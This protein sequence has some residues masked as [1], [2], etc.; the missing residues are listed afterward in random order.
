LPGV[1]AASFVRKG[2]GGL[3]HVSLGFELLD[4]LFETELFTLEF[5]DFQAIDEGVRH[6]FF[7]LPL[8]GLMLL[9]QFLDMRKKAHF[10]GLHFCLARYRT[11]ILWQKNE[12]NKP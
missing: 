3:S 7:Y 6:L 1:A 11:L 4:L 9:G 8:K 5:G 10:P 12:K 2:K